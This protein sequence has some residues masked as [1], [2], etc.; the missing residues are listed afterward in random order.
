MLAIAD[1]VNN[2]PSERVLI[3]AHGTLLRLL[4]ES[5]TE[6]SD[7]L[8]LDNT[9]VSYVTKTDDRWTCSIYNCTKHL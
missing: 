7:R 2:H 6:T 1:I 3:V 5:M 8:P 4:I 9:S